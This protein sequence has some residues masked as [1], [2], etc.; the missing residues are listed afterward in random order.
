M[1]NYYLTN[2]CLSI[3]I[4]CPPGY[5]CERLGQSNVTGKCAAGYF[6]TGF[7]STKNQIASEPGY[8]SPAGSID[9]LPCLPGTYNNLYHQ[10]SCVSCPAG[11]YCNDTAMTTY[12]LNLCPA[13]SYCPEGSTDFQECPAGTYS[14]IAGELAELFS[15]ILNIFHSCILHA[16]RYFKAF[17]VCKLST[18]KVL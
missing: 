7:A 8:F 6:C 17:P 18:G 13:G 16:C 4:G 10:E 1:R 12:V 2:K 5:Y 3:L 15:L 11:Y 9:Q 14:S